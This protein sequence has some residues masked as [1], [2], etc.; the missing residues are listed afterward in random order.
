MK[1]EQESTLLE[2]YTARPQIETAA[3]VGILE[4]VAF[5]LEAG[6][7]MEGQQDRN[8]RRNIQSTK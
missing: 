2:V 7:D 6:A 8:Y 5:L 1:L 4:I 3:E